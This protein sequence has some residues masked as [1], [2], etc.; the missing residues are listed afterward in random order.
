MIY[1]LFLTVLDC[2][3]LC[4]TFKILPLLMC[5]VFK[6]S[7]KIHKSEFSKKFIVKK[8]KQIKKITKVKKNPKKF[9][10]IFLYV[11][12]LSRINYFVLSYSRCYNVLLCKLSRFFHEILIFRFV[13]LKILISVHVIICVQPTFPCL[14]NVSRKSSATESL[15][16][17][18]PGVKTYRCFSFFLVFLGVL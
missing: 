7:I 11:V 4:V 13:K 3:A 5:N 6:I 9:K 18:V 10:N 12:G 15:P 17:I 16:I 1:L 2:Y 14:P 8:H